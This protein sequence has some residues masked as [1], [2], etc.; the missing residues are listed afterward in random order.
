MLLGIEL[1]NEVRPLGDDELDRLRLLRPTSIKFR[2]HHAH[3]G[4]A[5]QALNLMADLGVTP[6]VLLRP[7]EDG[8]DPPSTFSEIHRVLDWL[9]SRDVG[10]C[11][12]VD[13]EPNMGSRNLDP[14]GWLNG[15]RGFMENMQI[16]WPWVPL[17]SPGLAVLQDEESWNAM[18]DSVPRFIFRGNHFYWEGEAGFAS[19][20]FMDRPFQPF[21]RNIQRMATEVGDSSEDPWEL[22]IQ[23]IMSALRRLDRGGYV[24]A[25]LFILGGTD[26]WARFFPPADACEAFGLAFGAPS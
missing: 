20:A 22:K 21:G 1:P 8:S 18:L 19:P 16:H 5:E 10:A 26:E 15:W 11:V 13:N 12:E 24:A 7:D 2:P 9:G 14:R 23:R 4:A 25:Y 6:H 17:V 3:S